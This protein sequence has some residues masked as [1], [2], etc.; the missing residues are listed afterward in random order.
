MAA[1]KK[2]AKA[3]KRPAKKK[4]ARKAAA[5]AKQL[6]I[7]FDR[8]RPSP[9]RDYKVAHFIKTAKEN[10][11]A[12]ADLPNLDASHPIVRAYMAVIDHNKWPDGHELTCKFLDG[13][14]AWKDKVMA[15]AKLW[16]QYANVKLKFVTSGDAQVRISFQADPGS[17]S[18][19]GTDCLD[20]NSFPKNGPTMNFGWL[21]D[22]TDDQEY[23][24]VVVHEFGH[25]LG[26]IH[27]HQSPN[28]KLNWNVKE[29]YRVFSGPPNNWSKTEIDHNILQKYGAKGISATVFD[30][31]SIMLYQFDADLFTDHK[32]TPLNYQ[33]SD[34]D[35][36]MIKTMYPLA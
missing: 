24:R 6:H 28:E 18:A 22:D 34:L 23:E 16:E 27:E 4:A 13:K 31:A 10:K 17:W 29:V 26:C 12:L 30:P 2:S 20:A 25:A 15:K 7:C 35:K 3:P 32:A 19:V 14:Q 8:V 33:L 5:P 1:K 36:S 11:E 9:I 21:R